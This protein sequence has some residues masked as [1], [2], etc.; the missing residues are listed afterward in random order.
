MKSSICTALIVIVFGIFAL[1]EAQPP[2]PAPEIADHVVSEDRYPTHDVTFPNG[3][4]GIPDVLYWN[5]A[6]YR[7]VT[8]DLYIPPEAPGQPSDGYPLVVFIHPG[9]WMVGDTHLSGPFVDFPG[10]LASLSARGYV[11]ASVEYRL[12]SEAKFPAQIQDI[13]AAIRWLH[14][15]GTKYGIDPAH[16]VAWGVA[17]GAHLAVL[18]AVSCGATAL[19]PVQP[20]TGVQGTVPAG[21]S[22]DVSDCVQGAI[23]WCGVFDF[24]TIARQAREANALS[25]DVPEAPEWQLLG[26]FADKC[27]PEQIAAA[28]PV[29]YVD[30]QDPP[31][32]LIA[33]DD[34]KRAPQE[35]TL[36]MADKLKASGVKHELIILPGIGHNFIGKTQEATRDANMK[37]LE[38]TFRFI[39]QT[40][41]KSSGK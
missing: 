36:E 31:V 40:I 29:T 37:A 4:R 16:T 24:A 27:T 32:L 3:V 15:N 35:Q 5:P 9:G 14:S 19:E 8:L 6:G 20:S 28:S 33:G 23:S 41:G 34:D 10:L 1:A 38:A 2:S 7:P 30:P 25:R 12:S 22:A 13:K 26:C 39:D 17:A 11:V 18:A 21:G